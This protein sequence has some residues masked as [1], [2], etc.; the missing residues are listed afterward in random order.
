M[1]LPG[2]RKRVRPKRRLVMKSELM[3]QEIVWLQLLPD[4]KN[5]NKLN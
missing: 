5:S 4:N 1:E 2:R 3:P